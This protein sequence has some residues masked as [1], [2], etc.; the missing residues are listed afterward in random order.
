MN[1]TIGLDFIIEFFIGLPVG[2]FLLN[3]WKGAIVPGIRQ[4]IHNKAIDRKREAA[5]EHLAN[6]D[7]MN[8]IIREHKYASKVPQETDVT[9]TTSTAS[10]GF[11][12][13]TL[14][15]QRMNIGWRNPRVVIWPDEDNP[16][17]RKC[18]IGDRRIEIPL[19]P[20]VPFEEA[21]R[22]ILDRAGYGK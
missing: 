6:V 8:R 21:L 13:Q 15:D 14:E 12:W 1:M 17:I 7:E 19:R 20:E 16:D 18:E 10:N 9:A 4:M 11:V 3:A 5:M 2:V 22:D